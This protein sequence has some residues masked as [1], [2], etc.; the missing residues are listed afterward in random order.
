MNVVDPP[1]LESWTIN[2]RGGSPTGTTL[3]PTNVSNLW[4]VDNA[5]D[6]VYQ[7][8]AAASR[9]SGSQSPSASFG[10]AA[11]N[12]NPQG[13]ADPPPPTSALATSTSVSATDSSYDA[14][15]LAIVSELDGLL[16][17]GKKRT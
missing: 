1:L 9:T 7:F 13:I 4:I 17:G 5:T 16:T 8:D 15:L 6:R 3:D 2:S 11:G 14:A 10:L 12:T